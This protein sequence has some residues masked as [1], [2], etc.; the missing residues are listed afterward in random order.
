MDCWVSKS[1]QPQFEQALEFL[2]F[3]AKLLWLGET[4]ISIFGVLYDLERGNFEKKNY[5]SL[6]K[7]KQNRTSMR[8]G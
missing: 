4:P 8:L 1:V 7:M 2:G 6:K 3:G 5:L